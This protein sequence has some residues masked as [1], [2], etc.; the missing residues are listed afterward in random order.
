MID[1][2]G[3]RGDQSGRRIVDPTCLL[4]IDGP[5]PRGRPFEWAGAEDGINLLVVD[6]S[7][8]RRTLPLLD[9]GNFLL[10]LDLRGLSEI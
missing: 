6:E 1:L 8:A 9:F 3:V 4:D 5:L 10:H 2:L 7:T